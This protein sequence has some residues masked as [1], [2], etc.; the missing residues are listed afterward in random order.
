MKPIELKHIVKSIDYVNS[1]KFNEKTT[2]IEK[3]HQSQPHVFLTVLALSQDGVS[4][5]KV[6]HALNVL[7]IIHK[8]FSD[9][10]SGRKIS[11]ISK[12]MLD[13]AL[14]SNIAMLQTIEQGWLSTDESINS[15][16]E[17]NI[18]AYVVGYLK[19]NGL[20]ASSEENERILINLKTV[21]DSYSNA[22]RRA[23]PMH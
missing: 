2:E 11:L 7:L 10:P 8:I 6:E 15:Y 4:M 21:L 20:L 3:I 5:E 16:F 9:D 14:E 18:L 19:E 1:L 12:R 13:D 22:R 17:K 23:E